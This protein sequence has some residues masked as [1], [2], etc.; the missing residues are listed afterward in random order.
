M[1]RN[2]GIYRRPDSSLWWINATLPN[3]KRVRQS[4]GTDIKE[5]AE[6][7]LAKL[8]LDAYRES[9]FG[10]KPQRSWQEAVVRYLE[11]K[12]TLRSFSDVQRICRFLDP[13]LGSMMLNQIN[14]DVV[15]SVIQGELKKGNKPATVNRYLSTMRSLLRMARDEWQWIDTFPKIRLLGGEVERDRWLTHEEADRLIRCCAPHLAALVRFA[16]AT[17]CRA[18]EITGLEWNRV[19]L[20]RHTAWLNKTKNGTPR[21]VPLNEDAKEVL[22]EQI[23]KSLTHCFT[24]RGEPMRFQITNSAWHTALEAAG[25]SDFRFHDLRHTWASWHRQAGTSCDELKELGGWKS[26]EM[27]DRYAKY[28]TEHLATAAMRINRLK[29]ETQ[30]NLVTF[31]SRSERQKD[32]ASRLSP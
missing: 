30:G 31:L 11:L 13:Y 22:R 19:D 10:I 29:P 6:A 32:L 12:R 26:R 23:G 16:L 5:D 15:W 24:F 18:A 2:E 21:G 25:I 28:G 7:Y 17:G 27:V 20:N 3:G 14:G 1:A 4:A 8:K 9:H